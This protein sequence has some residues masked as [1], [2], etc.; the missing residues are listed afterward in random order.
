MRMRTKPVK[1]AEK[2]ALLKKKAEEEE[3]KKKEEQAIVEAQKKE[4]VTNKEANGEAGEKKEEDTGPAPV[5]N[6]GT[7]DKYT[8]TQTL[9]ELHVYIPVES[10]IKG[11][12]LK[13]KIDIDHLYVILF[14]KD[15]SEISCRL[16]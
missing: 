12:S 6:G 7:T 1:D 2:Q 13:V 14:I 15:P 11:K 8:W 5:G 10:S 4:E 16:E 9:E 3:A